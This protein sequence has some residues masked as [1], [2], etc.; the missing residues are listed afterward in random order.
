MQRAL[1]DYCNKFLNKW[2]EFA[3]NIL[4]RANS[5]W[6]IRPSHRV[7]PTHVISVFIKIH[8]CLPYR[9]REIQL[10]YEKVYVMETQKPMHV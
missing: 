2:I 4:Q 10:K 8:Y 9:V 6:L 1:T 5:C 7:S 3:W